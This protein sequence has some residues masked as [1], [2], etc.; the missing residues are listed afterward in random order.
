MVDSIIPSDVN[1]PTP[2][3]ARVGVFENKGSF[4]ETK[5][6]TALSLLEALEAMIASAP[7]APWVLVSATTTRLEFESPTADLPDGVPL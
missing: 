4:G 3:H 2:G 7:D 6:L 5:P 1:P